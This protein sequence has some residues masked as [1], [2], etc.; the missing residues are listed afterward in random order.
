MRRLLVLA[1]VLASPATLALPGEQASFAVLEHE[2]SLRLLVGRV[3]LVGPLGFLAGRP[4]AVLAAAP[5]ADVAS[6]AATGETLEF[7]DPNGARWVVREYVGPAGY[8]YAVSLG[9]RRV[10]P[11]AGAYDFVLVVDEAKL[12]AS[13]ALRTVGA[14]P[15]GSGTLR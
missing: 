6:L 8:A 12:P 14:L 10:D 9:E 5:G 3:D 7:S 11:A 1:L 2:G 13:Y 4:A 15:G